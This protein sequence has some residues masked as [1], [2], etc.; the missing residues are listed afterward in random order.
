MGARILVV[1]DGAIV[2]L[3]LAQE[4]Q[5]AGFEVIGPAGT[6][7]GALTLI[8]ENGCDAAVL[9]V[10]LGNETAEPV[11]REL[12]ARGTPFVTL[13][14]YMHEQLPPVFGCAPAL[15]K[16]VQMKTLIAELRRCLGS[17]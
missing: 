11:A 5:N 2:A 1:E 10:R 4:L 7:T 12:L 14:G 16:P 15:A 17:G 6:V 8:E 9:D 13:T 3:T